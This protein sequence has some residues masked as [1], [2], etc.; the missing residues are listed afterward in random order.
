MHVLFYKWRHFSN[1]FIQL[2]TYRHL[3]GFRGNY[4]Q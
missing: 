2:K 3:C 4:Q 1:K